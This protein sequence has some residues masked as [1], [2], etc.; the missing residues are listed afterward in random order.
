M[1]MLRL[2]VLVCLMF[3]T[4]HHAEAAKVHIET[5]F[6]KVK[7][8]LSM[9]CKCNANGTF[10]V[11][12]DEAPK[13]HGEWVVGDPTFLWSIAPAANLTFA[14]VTEPSVSL[15]LN[16]G[17]FGI[18]YK[19]KVVVTW[20]ETHSVTKATNTIP[21][22]PEE[23]TLD[24]IRLDGLTVSTPDMIDGMLCDNREGLVR[25][26]IK[27]GSPE[28]QMVLSFT[29]SSRPVETSGIIN[30]VGC[31][32]D[33]AFYNLLDP[34]IWTTS[35]IYWYGTLPGHCCYTNH[36]AYTFTAALD[37]KC[38]VAKD[39]KMTMPNERP[40][41]VPQPPKRKST[42][43][44]AV[45]G[46]NN[47]WRC[48]IEFRDFEKTAL[49]MGLPTTDQYVEETEKEETFHKGQWEGTVPTSEGGTGDLYT[50]TGCKYWFGKQ[51]D[52]QYYGEGAT[53]E[54]A[55]NNATYLMSIACFK[56]ETQSR[57]IWSKDSFAFIEVGAK[58]HAGFNAAWMYHCMYEEKYGQAEKQ[59]NYSH[60][61]H[62]N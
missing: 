24:A 37:S 41:M 23:M 19:V 44:D 9:T 50:A 8:D 59:V 43:G 29:L 14:T 2:L 5:S 34:L 58:K 10:S 48:N 6:Q 1:K 47:R 36:F 38:I 22:P 33:I 28:T 53:A 45:L 17:A 46:Q 60:P 49:I 61:A 30:K 11:V 20:V 51:D 57:S 16:E 3:G 27:G 62:G 18:S 52:D 26:I 56:E 55:E 54:E 12:I 32:T 39:Y 13:D 4:Y 42:R 35:P 15:S 21:A 7:D 25:I 31:G 40:V